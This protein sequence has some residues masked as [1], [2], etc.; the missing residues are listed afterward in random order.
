MYVVCKRLSIWVECLHTV[1]AVNRNREATGIGTLT[2]AADW[3]C[4]AVSL[5]W[6]SPALVQPWLPARGL[7]TFS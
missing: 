6:L 1:E 2:W 7:Y 3:L 5:H 4:E